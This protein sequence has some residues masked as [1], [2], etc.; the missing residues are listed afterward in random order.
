MRPSHRAQAI[1][2]SSR[3]AGIRPFPVTSAAV[4][5]VRVGTAPAAAAGARIYVFDQNFSTLA[6]TLAEYDPT[7]TRTTK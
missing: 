3:A 7:R 4:C 5:M 1:I 6:E 2:K